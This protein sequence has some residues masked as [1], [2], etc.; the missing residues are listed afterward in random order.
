MNFEK[1]D[2]N[3]KQAREELSFHTMIL[4]RVHI[5]ARTELSSV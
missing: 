1:I 3:F 2:E 4:E 5:R